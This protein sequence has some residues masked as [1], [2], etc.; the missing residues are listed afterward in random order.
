MMK[1]QPRGHWR[2]IACDLD[3]TLLGRGHQSNQA[4]VDALKR[5][6]AAGYHVT[7]CTGRN[8]TES[9]PII[10][11][12]GLNDLGIFVN[13][14]V[15]AD[16]G[17]GRTRSRRTV[18]WQLAQELIDFFGG[19]GHA[20]LT[21][22]D[23][24]DTGKPEYI[25]SS[26]APAHRATREWLVANRMSSSV[27]DPIA[28]QYRDSILRLSVVVDVGESAP[29]ETAMAQRFGDRISHY[30]IYS[31]VYDCQVLEAFAPGVTKWSGIC[32]LCEHIDVPTDRVVAIGDDRNDLP[33]LQHAALSIAMGNARDE[34]KRFAKRTTRSQSDCG[35]AYV[36]E[37]L[38]SGELEPA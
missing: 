9:A 7:I 16:M 10:A 34:I 22:A 23:D 14:A 2:V 12:L 21:L 27:Q 19:S 36:V 5:A 20:V 32:D 4:D 3:G 35:V 28:P 26:H 17:T 24:L 30:S 11:A 37:Q 18:P 15:I 25:I 29:L 6:M 8:A 31:G 33:M 38:L 1:N 13:G